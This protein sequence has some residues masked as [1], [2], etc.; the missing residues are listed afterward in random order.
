MLVRM[1]LASQNIDNL[2]LVVGMCEEIG[3]KQII[4]HACGEPAKNKH[5]TFGQAVG[6]SW[7][8]KDRPLHLLHAWSTEYGICLGQISVDEKSNEITAFPALIETLNLKKTIITTDALNTQ[9][10][11]AKAII[12]NEAD[13][14]LPIK[15]NHKGLYDDIQLLFQEADEKEFRG[16]D[17]AQN[18][19]L[20]KSAGRVEERLYDL[21]D[22]DE[23]SA[24]KEWVGSRSV[25]RVTRRR[26]K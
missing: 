15:E 9:K 4:D 2:G 17:S 11:S 20:E 8:K 19:S 7:N 14:I 21:I 5:L 1:K 23:L 22:I 16:I 25:G 24:Q 26:T 12:D 13:Y 18:S 6:R 10:K 3:I